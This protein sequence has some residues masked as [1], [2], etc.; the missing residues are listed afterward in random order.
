[1]SIV[2]TMF[3]V[4]TSLGLGVLQLNAGLHRMNSDIDESTKWQVIIIWCITAC[5]FLILQADKETPDGSLLYKS[6]WRCKAY[7]G[8]VNYI[9]FY[10]FRKTILT[11]NV[12][13]FLL[14]MVQST[15]HYNCSLRAKKFC[16]AKF[17]LKH[18]AQILIRQTSNFFLELNTRH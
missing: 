3:G 16:K 18:F 2:C 1:M 13:Q 11:C 7:A 14:S 9:F 17:H 4:C 12:S 5:K 10:F 8:G 6:V 15:G